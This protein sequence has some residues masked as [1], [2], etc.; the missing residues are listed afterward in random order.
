MLGYTKWEYWSLTITKVPLRVGLFHSKL[1]GFTRAC[2]KRIVRHRRVLDF[3]PICLFLKPHWLMH[4]WLYST[5]QAYIIPIYW[6][7]GTNV[8]GITCRSILH[9]NVHLNHLVFPSTWDKHNLQNYCKTV[10]EQ[11]S[12]RFVFCYYLLLNTREW[13][14]LFLRVNTKHVRSL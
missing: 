3:V 13:K 7:S 10:F 5:E 4:G 11:T 8:W 1:L 14:I 12:Y 2:H 6:L 9:E